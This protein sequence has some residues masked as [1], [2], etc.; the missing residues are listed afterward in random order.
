MRKTFLFGIVLL[1][2]VA[3]A[4]SLGLLVGVRLGSPV[5]SVPGLGLVPTAG[6]NPAAPPPKEVWF[7][8]GSRTLRSSTGVDGTVAG[9]KA[10]RAFGTTLLTPDEFKQVV[11]FYEAKVAAVEGLGGGA[12]PAE[13]SL[14]ANLVQGDL[15]R[16]VYY[17][18]LFDSERPGEVAVPRK[19]LSACLAVRTPAYDLT[20]FITRVPEEKQTHINLFF[21][22]GAGR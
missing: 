11:A 8:P 18:T 16:G 20:V 5:I 19:V 15:G 2:A 17:L 9:T 13:P 3:A 12:G 7:Y 10:V 22:Q 4:F 6:A 14:S 21:D 1:V